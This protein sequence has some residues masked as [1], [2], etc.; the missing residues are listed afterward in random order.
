MFSIKW[1]DSITL[2]REY[3]TYGSLSELVNFVDGQTRARSRIDA[4]YDGSTVAMGEPVELSG[5][6]VTGGAG[7]DRV[8][9]DAGRGWEPAE[10]VFNLL[11]DDRGPYLWSL[12]R[13]VWTPDTPGDHVLRV[14]AFEPDG[15]T[16]DT[17]ADFPYDSSAIHRVRV[18]VD[19]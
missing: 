3:A 2:A 4:L 16:Q 11:D 19:A 15:T 10:L 8:E 6:A 9:V 1:L 17:E 12:W 7:V 18:R 5:I 13:Y 14:R